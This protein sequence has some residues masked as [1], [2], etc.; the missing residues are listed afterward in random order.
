MSKNSG[1][2]IPLLMTLAFTAIVIILFFVGVTINENTGKKLIPISVIAIICGV[3]YESKRLHQSWSSVLKTAF[4]TFLFSF[5]SFIPGKREHTYNFENHIELW[6]Y[7]FILI[8]AIWSI[9][10]NKEKV[11]PK[12]TEGITLLQSITAVYWVVDSG[13]LYTENTIFRILLIIGLIFS[14]ISFIHAFSYIK[15]SKTSR[16]TLS[17]WSSIV[18]LLFA[19]DNIYSVYQNEQIE[20]TADIT[21]GLYIGLQFFLLGVTCIY[22][23]QNF[24]MLIGFLPAK[25]TFFNAQYFRELHE[26]KSDHIKRYSENQVLIFN[27]ILCLIF[28]SSLFFLNYKFQLLPTH[29]AIWLVFLIFPYF[30]KI[31][32]FTRE[33]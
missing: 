30:L 17:I 26:L 31:M 5:I 1:K 23:I 10:V 4:Y 12:L 14:L 11:I 33:Y 16:L 28:A 6:P 2:I 13:L 29:L 20:N 15:L 3:I 9:S 18:M 8:F 21:S 22:V 7:F 27:S 25:D 24:I 19:S 32:P